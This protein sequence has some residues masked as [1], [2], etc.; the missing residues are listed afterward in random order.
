MKPSR[1]VKTTMLSIQRASIKA[2]MECPV[3]S[4]NTSMKCPALWAFFFSRSNVAFLV[5][6]PQTLE[7]RFSPLAE[8]LKLTY[9]VLTNKASKLQ[10]VVG[11]TLEL[12]ELF[13]LSQLVRAHQH[14]TT[15]LSWIRKFNVIDTVTLDAF[16]VFEPPPKAES[17]HNFYVLVWRRWRLH[18]LS[19]YG[20][21]TL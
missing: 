14:Q 17:V 19:N 16:S 5:D 1:Y 8:W 15:I 6:Y 4:F 12:L 11:W 20:M 10:R 9:P 13:N 21:K 7:Y 18:T 3:L 2:V